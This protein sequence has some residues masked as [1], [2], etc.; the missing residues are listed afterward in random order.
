MNK[1][2]YSIIKY[3]VLLGVGA[4]LLFLAFKKVNINE[5][6]DK[7]KNAD[8][9][10]VM[11]SVIAS[12]IAF[13]SRAIRWNLLIHPLGYTPKVMNTSTALMIGYLANLA[14]PRLGE[15]TRCGTLT[16]SEKIP[17]DKLLGTVI[18]ERIIDVLSLLVCMMLVAFFEFERLKKFLNE[19]FI[20]TF[21]NKIHSLINSP[22][23]ILLTLGIFF[24]L[25]YLTF[26]SK[27]GK[28]FLNKAKVIMRGI[29]DGILSVR[30]M[31]KP[32]LF[33][34]HTVLIWTMYFFMS[35]FCFFALQSTAGLDWY[36]GLFILVVGGLGMS[37]PVP[38]G[39][40]AY[41]WAVSLGLML[42]GISYDD[43]I[44]FAT[45]MH[46]TNTLVVIVLGAL[47]FLYLFLKQRNGNTNA[48]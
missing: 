10:W 14:I 1:K 34:F 40:G 38:G 8:L 15:V 4:G 26:K 12:L 11:L 18:T 23:L 43:G 48:S 39:I 31:K 29:V 45:L 30:K 33:L 32:L 5:T 22:F 16:Q 46:T 21:K 7:I 37:A 25:V 27:K 9:F 19:N 6:I 3:A 42:F 24:T 36:A 44:T 47:S 41:H 2:I 13:F 17:F 35:Y 28:T 20:D